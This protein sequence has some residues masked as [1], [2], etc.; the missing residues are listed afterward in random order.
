MAHRA[1]PGLPGT[2]KGVLPAK[3]VVAVVLGCSLAFSALSW[4]QSAR[5]AQA[6][7]FNGLRPPIPGH[8]PPRDALAGVET[9]VDWE[10]VAYSKVASGGT[11][12][13]LREVEGIRARQ[14]LRVVVHVRDQHGRPM[15]SEAVSVWWRSKG[16][17]VVDRALTDEHGDAVVVR[18]IPG[19]TKG[20]TV[21]VSAWTDTRQWANG[22]YAW[23]VPE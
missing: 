17:A 9:S 14:Y 2:R 19:D 7:T 20:E 11:E 21:V 3:M 13:Q 5:T 23:F 16:L 4:T 10:R 18:W 22:T 6:I 8:T 12:A 15:R 1:R